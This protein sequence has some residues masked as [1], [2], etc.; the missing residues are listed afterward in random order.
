MPQSPGREATEPATANDFPGLIPYGAGPPELF[1]IFTDAYGR[2]PV[3]MAC[4]KF[5]E[6]GRVASTMH[7]RRAE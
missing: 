4:S 3:C 6:N 5:S 2:R 1:R 7:S